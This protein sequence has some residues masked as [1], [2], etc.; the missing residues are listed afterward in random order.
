MDATIFPTRAAAS[1]RTAETRTATPLWLRLLR[2]VGLPLALTRLALVAITLTAAQWR[3]AVPDP[4]SSLSQTPHVANPVLTRWYQWDAGWYLR[5]AGNGSQM[6]YSRYTAEAHHHFSAFAFFPLYPLLVRAAAV[7]VP[8]ALDSIPVSGGGGTPPASLVL[9]GLVVANLA[10]V[11]ALIALYLLAESRAGPG[12]AR[13]TVLLLCLFPTTIFFSAPYSESLFFLWLVL[14]FLCLDRRRW[15]LAGLCGLLASA[16]RSNGVFLVIPYLVAAW[17]DPHPQGPHPRP[18]SRARERGA[19]AAST[20]YGN[21][22]DRPGSAGVSPV[23]GAETD[24]PGSAGVS[25]VPAFDGDGRAAWRASRAPG[26]APPPPRT[27]RGALD[28][29]VPRLGIARGQ[30]AMGWGVRELL[31]IVL[32][33][34]GVV[35]YMAYQ[36]LAWGDPLRWYEAEKAWSRSLAL[37]WSGIVN[38]VTWSLRDWPHLKQPAWRGLTDALYALV[39]LALSAFAWRRVDW[40]GR[41]YMVVFWVYTLCEPA[42]SEPTHPDTLISMARLLLVLLPLW[43]WVGQSRWRTLAVALPSA[44]ILLFYAARWVNAGWIG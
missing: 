37:P 34:L 38:G 18:L 19:S 8:G 20:L 36:W 4:G 23:P 26:N 12:A 42:T 17:Q 32:I 22:K 40:P 10:F 44:F 16:T 3:V 39:F 11:L 43:L 7:L 41:A 35:G 1:V 29:R 13:R 25:P 15:W 9:A 14:F 31:P 28:R 33:P 30:S 2:D 24:R 21:E 5:I 6:G 27:G